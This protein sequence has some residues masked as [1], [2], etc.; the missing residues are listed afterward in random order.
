MNSFSFAFPIPVPIC[1]HVHVLLP[2]PSLTHSRVLRMHEH[3][4]CVCDLGLIQPEFVAEHYQHH[5]AG[6]STPFHLLA[7]D[8][9][10]PAQDPVLFTDTITSNIVFANATTTCKDI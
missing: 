4:V 9:W 2:S 8:S 6:P 7:L 1:V 5:T 10:F 3:C